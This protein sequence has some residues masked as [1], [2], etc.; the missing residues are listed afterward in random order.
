MNKGD[1]VYRT[2]AIYGAKIETG[3]CAIKNVHKNGFVA[4]DGDGK[5]AWGFSTI[6][7]AKT[8]SL[9]REDAAMD[10]LQRC[11][12][13]LDRALSEVEKSKRRIDAAREYAAA[14]A[15]ETRKP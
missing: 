9:T 10:Y 2:E 8:C 15:A 12:E 11:N 1:K 7:D 4:L 14:L 13:D 5:R 3:E 6:V